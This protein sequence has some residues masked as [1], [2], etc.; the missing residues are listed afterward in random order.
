MSGAAVALPGKGDVT[1]NDIAREAV[2]S[3]H[4]AKDAVKSKHILKN[5]VRSQ[6]VEGKSL[7]GNDLKD[8]A[9]GTKQIKDDAVTSQQVEAASLNG[10]DLSDYE[11][12]GDADGGLLRLTATEAASEAAARTAAPA[13]E[14]FSK[15]QLTISAKCFRDSTAGQTFAELTIA[16]SADGAIFDGSDELSGGPA[17]TDFLNDDTDED[18]RQ[19]D[20]LSV[21]GPDAELDEGEWDAVGADGTHLIGQSIIG[22]KDGDLA[23]GN[24]A[25]GAGNVCV[26]GGS[27]S[28]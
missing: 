13:T 19:L 23:G 26:F 7:K 27:V 15:G 21:V 22:V 18:L 10:S 20:D 28:G 12:L 11:S 2:K 14:L 24:G 8:G 17:A 9:I 1:S 16:T 3:K 5:A 6:E 4:V 25:Y